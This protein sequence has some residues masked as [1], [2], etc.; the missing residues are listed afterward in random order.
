MEL[1][2]YYPGCVFIEPDKDSEL[3]LVIE[4]VKIL[5]IQEVAF[6]IIDYFLDK[7]IWAVTMTDPYD[8]EE[9]LH[10]KKPIHSLSEFEEEK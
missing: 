10:S 5:Y 1:E 9:E 7:F 3:R 4:G 6:R 2:L 8:L